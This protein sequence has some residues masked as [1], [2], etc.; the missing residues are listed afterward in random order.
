[1]SRQV[2]S[3]AVDAPINLGGE[4]ALWPHLRSIPVVGEREQLVGLVTHREL[5]RAVALGR[6]FKA[7]EVMRSDY[8]VVAPTLELAEA[9]T[10][11]RKNSRNCLLVVGEEKLLGVVTAADILRGIVQMQLLE[12]LQDEYKLVK[13][14]ST[15]KVFT[16]QPGEAISINSELSQ[17]ERVCHLPVV[18]DL[19]ELVGVVTYRELLGFVGDFGSGKSGGGNLRV[20][21]L[22]QEKVPTTTPLT[23][24]SEA[25]QQLLENKTGCLPVID[26]NRLV[27]ILTAADFLKL[28]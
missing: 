4:L 27:G 7:S 19:K 3:I 21:D 25:A 18:N 2:F 1:M 6:E 26:K 23:L 8:A 9:A 28:F 5:L 16:L 20:R 22:M 17:W 15:K 24:L 10:I 13:Q 14:L 11:I 12:R